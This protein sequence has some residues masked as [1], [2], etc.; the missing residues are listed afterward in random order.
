MSTY[1]TLSA[2]SCL[3]R[4]SLQAFV[5]HQCLD[6]LFLQE[7]REDTDAVRTVDGV[8]RFASLSDQGQ[9]GCQIWVDTTRNPKA[10]DTRSFAVLHSHPR[11]L[12]IRAT[13]NGQ[14][15]LLIS[16][17]ARTS[18]TREEDVQAWWNM[19]DSFL[20]RA[21][22]GHTPIFGLDANAHWAASTPHNANACHME[23]L[24][25]HH[26]LCFSGTRDDSGNPLQT[27]TSPQG[28]AFCLDYMLLPDAWRDHLHVHGTRPILDE[29]A[30]IDHEPLLVELDI[31]VGPSASS[32]RLRLD[33]EKMHTD[34]GRKVIEAIF[35]S[36]PS[37]AWEVDVDTH[38]LMINKHFQQQLQRHFRAPRAQPRNP[39]VSPDTWALLV[40]KRMLRRQHSRRSATWA[41]ESLS[42]CF[43]TWAANSTSETA[44]ASASTF[45]RKLARVVIA[46]TLYSSRLKCLTKRIRASARSDEAS[47]TKRVFA[48][49]TREGPARKAHLIRAVLKSGRR[50]KPPG[51]AIVLKD[52]DQEITEPAQVLRSL[53]QHF[54]RAEQAT[55][56][57]MCQLN[58]ELL[59]QQQPGWMDA[60]QLPT[61]ADLARGFAGLKRRKAPGLSGIC[62]DF[63]QAAPALAA[64][65]H[66][67]LIL[68]MA[69]RG[70]APILWT[71]SLSI[72]LAKPAKD[73]FLVTG[74]RA[75]ALLE[76]SAKAVGRALRPQ[77]L[78][79]LENVVHPGTAGA[80][81]GFP[82]EVP[83]LTGQAFLDYLKANR[84]NG[85]LL[86]VDGISAF[87]STNRV[88]L[89]QG[90]AEERAK[91]IAALPL[92][93]GVKAVY[94][95]V[96]QGRSCLEHAQISDMAQ[97]LVSAGFR[98][99][100]FTTLPE[101]DLIFKTAAGTI[102]GAPLAD[103]LLQLAIA[104]AF[105]SLQCCLEREGLAVCVGN[106][107]AHLLTWLDDFAVPVTADSAEQ[108]SGRLARTA[109]LTAQA[110]SLTGV[111][112]NFDVGKSEALVQFFGP[113]AAAARE[114]LYIR[115]QGR[116]P[117]QM[118]A[119]HTEQLVCA[120][121][122]VHL[123]SKRNT[124]CDATHDIQR[125]KIQATAV[126]SQVCK[127]LLRNPELEPAEK[128]NFL[129]SLV[130][131]RFLHG[132]ATWA[133]PTAREKTAFRAAYI[134]LLRPA[135]RPLLKIPCWRLT[136]QQICTV[137]R[138][139]MPDEALGLARVRLVA[140]I[141][142]KG[143]AFL[144]QL[145]REARVWH[146][147]AY[148]DVQWLVSLQLHGQLERWWQH[149]DRDRFVDTWPLGLE[150]TRNL[151]R[152][153]RKVC[154]SR[155]EKDA[156]AI[157]RHA[158]ALAQA[159]QQGLLHFRLPDLKASHSCPECRGRFST[160]AALAAHRSKTHGRKAP[161]QA[162]SGTV[163]YCC[164]K[165]FWST[166]RL[167]EHMRRSAGCA[168]T[169]AQADLDAVPDEV[170]GSSLMPV[171]Q[172]IGPAPW[173]STLQP[174]TEEQVATAMPSS[175]TNLYATFCA[176]QQLTEVPVFLRQAVLSDRE[177][178]GSFLAD[179]SGARSATVP[180]QEFALLWAQSFL[181]DSALSDFEA[182]GFRLVQRKGD[183]LLASSPVM[184][185]LLTA[186]TAC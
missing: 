132:M 114:A 82:L 64:A 49:A 140:Q 162:A 54:A 108:L 100:W 36:T 120:E 44:S 117:V 113:G 90:T 57:P 177:L 7:T 124:H 144:H 145:L 74:Y 152:K 142:L 32:Q 169:F 77:L 33:V 48:E 174:S 173:W 55:A 156:P 45:L 128:R 130:L 127:R 3:Q 143:T 21:P 5:R 131:G 52:G 70:A 186:W 129:F 150:E 157:V 147:Q 80:R 112:M 15:L 121:H 65:Q 63:Y 25:D 92:E 31:H 99:T 39:V 78:A 9:L 175:A 125:R 34:E 139:L 168:A 1:N 87:Y 154:I 2:K 46:E 71:G 97:R 40:K 91:W 163:C 181:A 37:P 68:K 103:L 22:R 172:F 35:R 11:L 13:F 183:M 122:Y 167:R 17:H 30:G 95:D 126:C 59:P 104:P 107:P 60:Q 151:L 94:L 58:E 137:L 23:A 62:G 179:H 116:I 106:A 12:A 51:A 53:G 102:P 56:M 159:E 138:A 170:L 67:P 171:T 42:F 98:A 184:S 69:A 88:V 178:L 16:G 141:K 47:F 110:L 20:R 18:K 50:Y 83:S 66:Y 155:R 111:A 24:M 75:I 185:D 180:Q 8:R 72:P 89:G 134:G 96:V 166:R 43:R 79:G 61:V 119:G 115:A 76:S 101:D 161:Q 38:L 136:H 176:I 149:T 41:R 105:N 84:Q 118:P 109:S 135:V 6:V 160:P 93:P 29:H 4:H 133:L 27:W 81:R 28:Q 73:R 165:Q 19:L 153:A 86:Y 146:E 182:A 14:P 123:G 26:A 10:W 85:A 148:Q 164:Q 158:A